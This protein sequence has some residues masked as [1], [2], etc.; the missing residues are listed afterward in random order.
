VPARWLVDGMNVI[1][2]RPTGWWRDRE[3]AWR[4][5]RREL[6]RYARAS[7]D[8]VRLIL[9][10]RRPPGWREGGAVEVAFARGERGAGDEAI[11]ARVAAD[12]HP[13]SLRVVTSDKGLAERVAELG[14]EVEGAGAFLRR[15]EGAAGE[16]GG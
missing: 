4:E 15:M 3:R 6:E 5:L 14:A 7:G 2:S 12:P 9:D 1:G 8:D 10:G 13:E 11:V 16:R